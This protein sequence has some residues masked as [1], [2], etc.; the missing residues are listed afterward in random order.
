MAQVSQLVVNKTLI[1]VTQPE[2]MAWENVLGVEKKKA[3]FW[4]HEILILQLLPLMKLSCLFDRCTQQDGNWIMVK[5][6]AF[7]SFNIPKSSGQGIS[8]LKAPVLVIFLEHMY[9][10]ANFSFFTKLSM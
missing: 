8:L 7:K 3:R 10:H 2:G 9:S 5:K 1:E 4:K 6:C